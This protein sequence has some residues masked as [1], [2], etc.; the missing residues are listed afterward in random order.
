MLHRSF[1]SD[2]PPHET[3]PLFFDLCSGCL[4]SV[5]LGISEDQNIPREKHT[6]RQIAAKQP[7]IAR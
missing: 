5:S 2:I 7:V 6:L 3:T 4:R 1:D